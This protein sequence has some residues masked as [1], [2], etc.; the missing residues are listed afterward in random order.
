[1]IEVSYHMN[2]SLII[3]TGTNSLNQLNL[4][5]LLLFL[6]PQDCSGKIKSYCLIY[7]PWIQTWLQQLP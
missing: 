3:A 2:A 7:I 5:D 1:M 4:C 6:L